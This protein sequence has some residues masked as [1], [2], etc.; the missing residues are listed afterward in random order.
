MDKHHTKPAFILLTIFLVPAFVFTLNYVFFGPVYFNQIKVFAAATLITLAVT[1]LLSQ[2][3]IALSNKMRKRYP[4]YEQSYRRI[5]T[6]SFLI[7]PLTPVVLILLFLLYRGIHF[8]AA[9]QDDGWKWGIL[10][11]FIADVIGVAFNEGIY[12]FSIWKE[13]IQEAE[14]LKKANLQT[15]FEGLKNQVNPHFLF[16]SINTLSSLIH[17]DKARAEKFIDEMSNVYR[18]LLR[19]NEEELVSLSTELKFINSYYH[20]LKTRYGNAIGMKIS[21]DKSLENYLLPPLTLQLLVENAVKHNNVLKDKPLLIEIY[22]SKNGWLTVK[23]NLQKKTTKV[24]S[25]KVGLNNIK[26][27]FRLLN[28]PEVQVTETATDFTVRIPLIEKMIKA[29]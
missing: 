5:F 20:L 22:D 1:Y 13:N 10:V 25:S 28:Q 8:P 19:N 18:Y 29:E 3:Q 15:Q 12:T 7:L 27:K 9:L 4:A 6:W 17:E 16:N 26:E 14:Q 11:G 23:N 24:D 2:L 21:I